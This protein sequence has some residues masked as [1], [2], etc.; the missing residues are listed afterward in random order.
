MTFLVGQDN[1]QEKQKGQNA[2]RQTDLFNK[3]SGNKT[4]TY[5]YIVG[6]DADGLGKAVGAGYRCGHH[7]HAEG[8]NL[9]C[10]NIVLKLTCTYLNRSPRQLDNGKKLKHFI[11]ID[12]AV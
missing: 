12:G 2:D 4:Q 6:S 8:V 3:T 7:L 10:Y 9:I 1:F 11:Y 5:F